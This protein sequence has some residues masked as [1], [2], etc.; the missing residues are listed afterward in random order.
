MGQ[1]GGLPKGHK[2]PFEYRGT[3]LGPSEIG[4]LQARIDV[5]RQQR[6][7]AEQAC[8]E[9][10]WM[11]PN[12]EPAV[13]S[14]SVFLSAL[15]KRGVLSFPARPARSA[16]RSEVSAEDDVAAM[17]SALG[18]V[19]GFVECQPSG[20]LELRVIAREEWSGFKLHMERYHYLGLVKP[21]GESL[22]YAAFIG[23]ELVALLM[24]SAPALHNRPRDEYLGW[25]RRA[26]ERNLPWVVNNTR[27]L[28]LPWIRVP[29]L[30]SQVL[31]AN[32]RRLSR[33]WRERYGHDVLLAETFVD[34]ARYKGT[35]YAASNWI[36]VGLTRGWS[37]RRVGFVRH[38]EPKH[39][40]LR[41]LHRKA[42]VILR[43][44]DLPAELQARRTAARDLER[45]ED[46]AA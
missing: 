17:L 5:E 12:G 45:A 32:L 18:P 3:I 16:R 23:S 6:R 24:W 7:V 13:S 9:F 27:F 41:S 8:R 19:P 14:C 30:A 31:G 20:P 29:C 33:D 39:V 44:H 43:D 37:R 25:D 36:N 11:R 10:G 38:G 2:G 21:A 26:R 1:A 15:A 46:S 35:C 28:I 40:F 22:C 34:A 42:A 4:W